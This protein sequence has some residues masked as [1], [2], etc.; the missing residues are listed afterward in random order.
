[1]VMA[2][3][4]F[5]MG[6]NELICNHP[7]Y[8]HRSVSRGSEIYQSWEIIINY[9]IMFFTTLCFFVGQLIISSEYYVINEK[10]KMSS[11]HGF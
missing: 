1:M 7:T 5:V 8:R 4:I 9:F 3:Y 10:H 6:F 2:S 11:Q